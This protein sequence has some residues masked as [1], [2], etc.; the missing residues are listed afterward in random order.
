MRKEHGE[1]YGKF[2]RFYTPL[3][4]DA[5]Q[6]TPCTPCLLRISVL[7]IKINTLNRNS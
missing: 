1:L 2:K 4:N 7:K 3:N 6:K 5:I